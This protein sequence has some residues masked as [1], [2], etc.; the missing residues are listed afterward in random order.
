MYA[1]LLECGIR[2]AEHA[3]LL[4]QEIFE[5]A[6]L[7]HNFVGMYADLCSRL[8]FDLGDVS[9]QLQNALLQ[10]CEVLFQSSLSTADRKKKNDGDN[11]GD[12]DEEEKQALRRKRMLGTAR[13][14]GQ[15]FVRCVASSDKFF[16]CC[17]ELLK[18]HQNEH[19]EILAAI[20]TVVGPVFDSAECFEH[21]QLRMVFSQ[22]R[23]LQFDPT[24]P[25]RVKCRIRD[26]FDL[27]DSSWV[28][29]K[30]ALMVEAP[31][32]LAE[33]KANRRHTD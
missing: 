29:T 28:D 13:F 5:Q 8:L 2:T 19:I 31:K 24:V 15:L 16:A 20:L 12:A 11:D 27:R 26:V 23:G 22:L 18:T 4:A 1:K 21:D 7:Q 6:T 33:V 9:P 32:H 14:F 10:H 17:T 3:E 25:P 30:Q